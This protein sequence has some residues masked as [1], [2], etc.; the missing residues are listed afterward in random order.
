MIQSLAMKP[1]STIN[2]TGSGFRGLSE[3]SSGNSHGS[4]TNFPL[5]SLMPMET[6]A[7][8]RMPGGNFL[9]MS[10]TTSVPVVPDGYYLL[11]V[12]TN[13]I[14]GGR[15]V[16]VDGV[17]PSVPEVLTPPSGVLLNTSTPVFAGSA[18]PASRVTISVDG[19]VAGTA[20]TDAFGKLE[21]YPQHRTRAGASHCHGR[22]GLR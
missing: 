2:V 20:M 16:L 8:T 10:V 17:P 21:L 12:M 22:A 3:A 19:T 18:E 1:G 6:E 5:L 9:D 15:M 13:A 7:L 11:T 4:A 14:S